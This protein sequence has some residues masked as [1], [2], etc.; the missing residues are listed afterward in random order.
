M[1]EKA[2]NTLKHGSALCNTHMIDFKSRI[3]SLQ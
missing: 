3:L 1:Y 2:Y